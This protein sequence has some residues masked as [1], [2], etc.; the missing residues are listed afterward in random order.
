MT[1]V[2]TGEAEKRV[3]A[4]LVILSVILLAAA[5]ATLVVPRGE[6]ER[7]R[8]HF[9]KL[10]AHT[11]K[12]G[13]DL[14]MV[15]RAVGAPPGLDLQSVL[16]ADTRLPVT[17]LEA[18]SRVLVATPGLKRT[19]IVP[20]TYARLEGESEGTSMR[21]LNAIGGMALAPIRGFVLRA[22]VIGFV[23]LI[24]AVAVLASG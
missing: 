2:A 15:A 5:L 12:Q 11:V 22:E 23:L 3:P 8:K 4:T 13:E 9:P 17:S 19:A 7:V 16:D 24:V 20:G 18:G 6:Y 1:V 21:A 14:A 10:V